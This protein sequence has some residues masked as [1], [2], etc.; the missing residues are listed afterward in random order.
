VSASAG[1]RRDLL[2]IGASR[3]TFEDGEDP[4]VDNMLLL[5]IGAVGWGLSLATYRLLAQRVS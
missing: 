1:A 4:L 3:R 2:S 5:A